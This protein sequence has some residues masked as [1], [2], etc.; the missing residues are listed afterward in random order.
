MPSRGLQVNYFP[1]FQTLSADLSPKFVCAWRQAAHR[2]RWNAEPW[3][4]QVTKKKDITQH[5]YNFITLYRKNWTD[6]SSTD[7]SLAYRKLCRYEQ[8]C[9]AY[10]TTA[11]SPIQSPPA[12][13]T[14]HSAH[15][16]FRMVLTI[17]S[18]CFPTLH[19]PV[20]LTSEDV[21]CFLWGKNWIP[22]YHS[23]EI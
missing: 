21:M 3:P 22:I 8:R 23:G 15:G 18:D 16:V 17:N 12:F 9:A 10:L 11:L 13:N 19:Q 7:I 6:N 2:L 20:V 14:L 5:M 1:L 4:R